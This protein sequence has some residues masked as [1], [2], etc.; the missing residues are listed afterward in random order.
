MTQFVFENIYLPA[1]AMTCETPQRPISTYNKT[2][3]KETSMGPFIDYVRQ[4][5]GFLNPHPPPT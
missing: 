1:A 5:P 2:G 4:F 3:G